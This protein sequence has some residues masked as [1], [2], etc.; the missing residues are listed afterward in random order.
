MN[1]RYQINLEYMYDL[2]SNGIVYHARIEEYL[3]AVIAVTDQRSR[4]L[5][6]DSQTVIILHKRDVMKLLM[7]KECDCGEFDLELR[8]D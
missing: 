8:E 2:L 6:D 7:N 1:N 5:E 4:I 3:Y